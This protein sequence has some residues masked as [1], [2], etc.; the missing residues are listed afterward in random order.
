M[1]RYIGDVVPATYDDVLSSL[2]AVYGSMP[3]PDYFA[4]G[5]GSFLEA[6]DVGFHRFY[7][8]SLH[9]WDPVVT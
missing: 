7:W 2:V 4:G 9:D 5:A 1:R 3:A 8:L 6:F